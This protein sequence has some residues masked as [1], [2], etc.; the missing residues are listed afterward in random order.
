MGFGWGRTQNVLWRLRT[1]AFE[2]VWPNRGV[3]LIGT[4]NLTGTENAR[5][6]TP[7]EIVESIDAIRSEIRGRS[8][9]SRIILMAILPRG[10]TPDSPL[11]AAIQN[12]NPLLA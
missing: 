12:T 6:N 4:N 5:S 1:G 10:Q 9:D 2:R 3:L 11:R 7:E 8:P